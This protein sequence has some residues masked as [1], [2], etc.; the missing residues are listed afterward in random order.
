MSATRSRRN[1]GVT[2]LEVML[3]VLVLLLAVLG[4]SKYR[5]YAYLQARTADIN[6]SA[7]RIASLL[8]N[9]WKGAGGHS[10]YGGF[11]PAS[12]DDWDP[13]AWEP[14]D[15]TDWD[16]D[17]LPDDPEYNYLSFESRL[18]I[19]N[20]AAGPAVPSGF[21]PLDSDA[22]PN[23]HVII[24]GINYYATLSYK[25]PADEPRILNI[26][27]AWMDDYQIWRDGDTYQS[28][29]LTTLAND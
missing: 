1:S 18:A 11:E 6:V 4:T 5:S 21:S 19:F 24:N 7:A 2:L 23:Y 17:W 10:G 22:N 14:N 8:L 15:P 28:V 9:G 13:N 29:N 16:Q 3:A 27:V 20:G 25:D 12:D 26:C